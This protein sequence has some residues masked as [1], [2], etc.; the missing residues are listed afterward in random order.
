MSVFNIQRIRVAQLFLTEK[1]LFKNFRTLL[2]NQC[3][4]EQKA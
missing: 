4:N 2:L 3:E 1:Y